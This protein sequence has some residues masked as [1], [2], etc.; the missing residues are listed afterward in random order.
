MMDSTRRFSNG[1]GNHVM[2]RPGFQSAVVGLFKDERGLVGDVIVAD[3]GSGTGVLPRLFL[4]HGKR[5]IKNL[6]RK[7]VLRGTKSPWS[8]W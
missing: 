7:Q 3:V 1:N 6:T 2:F 4:G 8:R 5:V